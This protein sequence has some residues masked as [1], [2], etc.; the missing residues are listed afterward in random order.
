MLE[1]IVDLF[2]QKYKQKKR[3]YVCLMSRNRYL[4]LFLFLQFGFLAE[5]LEKD[6]AA[7]NFTLSPLCETLQGKDSQDIDTYVYF[8]YLQQALS[9]QCCSMIFL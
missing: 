8:F 9:F 5:S 6:S 1:N 4:C 3:F 2:V 7:V